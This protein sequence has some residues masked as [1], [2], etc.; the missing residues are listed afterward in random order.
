M[1]GA[2][3]LIIFGAAIKILASACKDLSKLQ[4]DELGRGL[5]GVGVLFGE[6]AVFLRVAKFNGKMISTATGIVILAAAMKVL[7]SACKDF[8]QMEWSEIGKGL[9]GIGGL[10][11]ELAVFT[12]LAGNAKHV[13]S[14]GV[15]LTAI[16][17]AMKIFASAVK[18]FG[19]LQWDEI[20]RG[21]TAMGGALAE[22]AIAVNLMPKNMIGIGTG[23]VIVGG[24]LE[25]I[26]NC[27]SKFGGMQWEEIG[28]GLTVM[29]GALAELSISLN[30]MK[31]TL[32]GSAALLVASA[33]LAVLAPVLSILGALS[34]EAIAKGLISIAGAFTIIG[35]AGAVLTPLV[36][37]ILALSGAFAL[38]GVGVVAF[39]TGNNDVDTFGEKLVPFG[40]AM[41][42]YSE[43]IMGMDSAAI[44]N[45]A[46][47]GKAL[48]ELANTIPNTG[49]LVSWF[50]GDNDLGSFG[51][52]LVQ[53]GS[54]IKSYSDSIS[55]ID[56]GI[57]SSVITQVNRLVE[58]AKGMAELDMS[59]MSGFSTALIQLGNNGI[60]GFI[61]AFT[62][63][64]GR[65]TS[66][67]TSMLTTFIN[68]ANAQK[69]N[70]TSIHLP[71]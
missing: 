2:T 46:T 65:V 14:T 54:G 50:T 63:A 35:V 26:A 51:D 9:A 28:R 29:G 56:T 44:T 59:G 57:M 33:A 38:I 21:L 23:L 25:I 37:T 4:W 3:S 1:K 30:F 15:A 7:T 32:G 20:G 16:G 36:P 6:I 39:F 67:A 42:A 12:N 64:S 34:W 18:D 24:A 45:S 31:G 40:E 69:G 5:T 11:A 41:K 8:G 27:M 53:F 62:D 43:A 13:M 55:G 61:N 22:V 70:L 66:A 10:L 58:M 17:A 49:G 68:A 19:Q 47:A 60:D 52:S 48:V 71:E